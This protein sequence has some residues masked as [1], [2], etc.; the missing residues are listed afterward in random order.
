MAEDEVKQEKCVKGAPKWMCTFADLMSL[1]LCFFVLLL[2]FSVMDQVK[3]KEVAGSLKDAF[4]TTKDS[5]ELDSTIMGQQIISQEFQTVPLDVQ[6]QIQEALAEEIEGGLVAVEHNLEGMTLQ[7]KGEVAFDSGSAKILPKFSQLLDKIGKVASDNEL[8]VVVSGHTDNVPVRKGVSFT[9]NWDLSAVRAVRVV[10]YWIAKFK[11]PPD[12]LSAKGDADGK[13]LAG[14]DTEV[15]RGK[16]RRV[17]FL[18]RPQK[19]DVAFEGIIELK[20]NSGAR[21]QNSEEKW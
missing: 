4:G 5:P 16:N 3:Y 6:V 11:I 17:E 1:L 21:S 14:N 19:P 15:G 20:E 10:E 13:P 9:S 2:S 18:I 7:V 8:H 12:R